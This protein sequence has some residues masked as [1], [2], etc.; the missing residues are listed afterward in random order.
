MTNKYSKLVF[1][2]SQIYNWINQWCELNLEGTFSIENKD[3]E[4]RISYT[5][6]NGS[7]EIKIDFVK[8]RGGALTIFPGVGKNIDISELI[9]EDIYGRISSNLSKS[10]LANGFSIKMSYEDFKILID[11]LKEYDDITLENY[12]TQD[13]S[14]RQIYELYRFKS[15]LNDS[16]VVKY[17]NNTNRVQIQGKPLYLFNEIMSLICQSEGNAGS[18]VDAHIEICNL[19]VERNELNDELKE[20][21]GPDVYNFMSITHRAMLSTSLVLSRVRIDGLD[22]YSYIIQQALRTY[23]GFT[24]KMMSSK[25]CILPHRKQIGEFF[26]RASVSDSFTMKEKYKVSLNPNE[27]ALFEAM[28]NFFNSKRHPYMHSSDIDATTTIIGTYEGALERLEEVIRNL[29]ESYMR[30]IYLDE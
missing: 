27:I 26:C 3:T 12:S 18:V 28:Y 15:V 16:V 24:L 30:L 17:F 13:K 29:K 7:K 9:A 2:S 21:L 1:D 10:P 14:G 25:G 4:Q 20:I 22:D 11:L 8:A 5:I 6:V 23:E 19:H